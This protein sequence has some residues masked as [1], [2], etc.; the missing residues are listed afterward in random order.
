[1]IKGMSVH[2]GEEGTKSNRSMVLARVLMMGGQMEH[3]LEEEKKG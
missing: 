2:V 3:Y 1:M